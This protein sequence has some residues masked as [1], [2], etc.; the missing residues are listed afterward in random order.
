LEIS[1]ICL[2]DD[3]TIAHTHII[4]CTYTQILRSDL[5]EHQ[6]I[7]SFEEKGARVPEGKADSGQGRKFWQAIQVQVV[8]LIALVCCR[9]LLKRA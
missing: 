2:R 1:V 4:I 7:A 5:N 3:P 9:V 8:N 6:Q